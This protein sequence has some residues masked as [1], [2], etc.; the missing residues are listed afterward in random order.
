MAFN[1]SIQ[2]ISYFGETTVTFGSV[3]ASSSVTKTFT[4]PA[5]FS[6]DKAVRVSITSTIQ[7]GLSLGDAWISAAGVVSIKMINATVGALHQQVIPSP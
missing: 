7:D 2:P 4:V 6:T 5:Q 3:T 1:V